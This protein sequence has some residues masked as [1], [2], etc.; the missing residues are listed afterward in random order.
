MYECRTLATTPGRRLK[1]LNN[2]LVDGSIIE[3]AGFYM[4]YQSA[5]H[6]ISTLHSSKHLSWIE[7][8]NA[9]KPICPVLLR[10]IKIDKLSQRDVAMHFFQKINRFGG[11]ADHQLALGRRSLSMSDH[12]EIASDVFD[13]IPLVFTSCGHVHSFSKELSGK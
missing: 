13:G 7:R 9:N 1:H 8:I 2:E 12:D 5:D 11:V 4:L 10:P 6:A 3:V